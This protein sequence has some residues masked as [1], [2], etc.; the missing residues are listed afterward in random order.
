MFMPEIAVPAIEWG[1]GRPW[2]GRSRPHGAPA[3]VVLADAACLP[4]LLASALTAAGTTVLVPHTE[5]G[6]TTDH[7]GVTVLTYE[8]D[9]TG[10]GTGEAGLHPDFYLHTLRYERPGLHPPL[11]PTLLRA[12]GDAGLDAYLTDADRART[13]GDFAPLPTHPAV[14][15]ADHRALGAAPDGDGPLLRLHVTPDGTVSTTP[16]GTPLGDLGSTPGELVRAWRAAPGPHPE[17]VRRPWLGRYLA[18]VDAVRAA[19][20]RGLDRIRVSGFGPRPGLAPDP[21]T[22]ADATDPALPLLLRDG[23]RALV[24]DPRS[25]RTVSLSAGAAH[26]AE[27]LLATGDAERASRH[28]DP[29]TIAAV[30]TWFGATGIPLTHGPATGPADR[31]PSHRHEELAR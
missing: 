8:G 23:D 26:A 14:R 13:E 18:A 20:T 28:A 21:D 16:G 17:V 22:A 9:L 11:A 19:R 3:T 29:A 6:L 4:R 31:I 7:D 5:P 10:A 24:H 30:D 15:L 2:P 12:D 1:T 25:G 27:A